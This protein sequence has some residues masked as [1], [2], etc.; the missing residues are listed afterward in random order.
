MTLGKVL[1]LVSV[2]LLLGIGQ[3]LFKQCS[4]VFVGVPAAEGAVALARSP[5]FFG[6]L[7]IYGFA[8]VLWIWALR[9]VPLA[10]AYCFTAI[11]FVVVPVMA[12]MF[13]GEALNWKLLVGS[14]IVGAGI[15]V[16]QL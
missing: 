10:R 5:L 8:T 13:L 12:A 1:S 2:A 3:L 15:I 9:D 4:K 16:T 7:V 14:L 6:A 11:A